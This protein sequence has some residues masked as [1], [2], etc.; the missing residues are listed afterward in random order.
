MTQPTT[1]ICIKCNVSKP[2]NNEYFGRNGKRLR[3]TCKPCSNAEAKIFHSNNKERINIRQ[4]K[5]KTQGIIDISDY[6]VKL[7]LLED[8]KKLNA[9]KDVITPELLEIKRNQLNLSRWV[10][11]NK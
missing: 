8:I 3:A 6:Y 2:N 4:L 5:F 10:N 11:D 9:T 1:K 7:K